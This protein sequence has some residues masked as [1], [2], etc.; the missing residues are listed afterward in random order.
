MSNLSTADMVAN[1]IVKAVDFSFT[2]NQVINNIAVVMNSILA[3]PNQDMV[4][5]G[6]VRPY[7]S[8][9]MN[10]AID[11]VFAHCGT[12]GINV[13]ETEIKQPISIETADQ[14]LDRIDTIQVRGLDELYDHQDRGFR[15]PETNIETVDNIPTKKRIKLEIVVKKGNNGSV[16]SATADSGFV[17]L[18][19]ISIPAGTVTIGEENIKNISAKY[20]GGENGN[21]TNQNTRTFTPGYLTDIME[22]FLVSHGENGK[23]KTN[24]VLAS[25]IKFGNGTEEVNGRDI[26]T[27][28]SM[29]VAEVQHNA[30]APISEVLMTMAIAMNLVYPYANNLLS[31]YELLTD[32]P[33]ATSTENVD[34][35]TGGEITIDGVACSEGQLVFLKEQD[36]PKENGFWEVQAGVWKRY[37]GYTTGNTGAFNWRLVFNKAGT[38]NRGKVFYIEKKSVIGTDNLIFRESILSPYDLPGKVPLRDMNGRTSENDRLEDKIKDESQALSVSYQSNR[39]EA[40]TSPGIVDSKLRA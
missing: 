40:W 13:V 24:S 8:G 25:M 9:G 34:I 27:G 36:N 28:L 11:P 2:N 30:L 16:L 23:L 32:T 15:D 22:K 20:A 38:A 17:K 18:A 39:K 31:R 5:G 19:E 7:Q 29:E 1:E 26:P 33:V 14:S 21:W 10:V 6:V 4:I 3:K 37:A 35:A 12:S